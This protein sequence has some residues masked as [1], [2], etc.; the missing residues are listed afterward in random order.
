MLFLGQKL[1]NQTCCFFF[2]SLGIDNEDVPKLVD[3]ILKNEQQQRE[4][5][6]VWRERHEEC[7]ALFKHSDF[8]SILCA[9]RMLIWNVVALQREWKPVLRIIQPLTSSILTMSYL[10]W[11]VSVTSIGGPGKTNVWLTMTLIYDCWIF[12]CY[13]VYITCLISW[14]KRGCLL[15]YCFTLM[16]ICSWYFLRES[17]AKELSTLWT[18]QARDSS[19]DQTYWD[20][21]GNIIPEDKVKLWDAA[22]ETLRQYQ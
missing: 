21:L 7:R 18:A 13:I 11:K 10:L 8:L 17:G 19:K 22:E 20:S 16:L 4:Q 3:F 6:K 15:F 9:C 2:Q 14:K 5:I 1:I 12:L